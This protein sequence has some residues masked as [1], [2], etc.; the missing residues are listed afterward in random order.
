MISMY[1]IWLNY[2]Y[3]IQCERFE[4]K[5]HLISRLSMIVRWVNA[6]ILNGYIKHK[7]SIIKMLYSIKKLLYPPPPPCKVGY[8]T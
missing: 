8:L 5:S 3:G 4:P 6:D 1:Y 7:L 2:H